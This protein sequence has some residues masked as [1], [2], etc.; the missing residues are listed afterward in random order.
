M[1]G[2]DWNKIVITMDWKQFVVVG[3]HDFNY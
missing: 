2:A 3:M 1:N